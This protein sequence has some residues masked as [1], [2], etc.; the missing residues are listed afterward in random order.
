MKTCKF[1]QNMGLAKLL[2]SSGGSVAVAWKPLTEARE[3]TR[4]RECKAQADVCRVGY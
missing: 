3:T 1:T 2:F 4:G